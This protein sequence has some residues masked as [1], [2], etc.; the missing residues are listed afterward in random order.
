[1]GKPLRKRLAAYDKRMQA[2]FA[3]MAELNKS[4]LYRNG[5]AHAPKNGDWST[6]FKKPGS[7]NPR[8]VR[9]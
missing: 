6:A 2:Y 3:T 8:K 5:S 4:R 9:G 7:L 1:M